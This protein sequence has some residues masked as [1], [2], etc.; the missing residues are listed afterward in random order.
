MSTAPASSNYHTV[1]ENLLKQRKNVDATRALKQQQAADKKD[2]KKNKPNNAF[3]RAEKFIKEFRDQEREQVR[4]RRDAKKEDS[5]PV[6]AQP[7]LIFVVR[8]KTMSKIAPK[9]RKVLQI[10]RLHQINNGVFVRLTKATAE[11]L[12]VVEPYVSYGFPTLASVRQ[13]VYKRGY[14]KVKGE[15]VALTDNTIIEEALGDHGIICLE[16]LIHELYTVGPAFKQASNF[17]WPFKLSN[18]NGGFGVQSK[19]K[20]TIQENAPVDKEVNINA[21]IKAQN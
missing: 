17:L 10:L 3:N 5:I 6:P 19:L 4:L 14:G 8:T 16:D 9:P 20:K 1:P 12:R 2:A 18:A 11:L 7:K 13:L 15:R 21:I